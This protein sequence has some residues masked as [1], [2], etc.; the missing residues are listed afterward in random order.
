MVVARSVVVAHRNFRV[1]NEPMKELG[2]TVL[3]VARHRLKA[4]EQHVIDGAR[5]R[6]EVAQPL[7]RDRVSNPAPVLRGSGSPDE[8]P[9]AQAS[10][11]DGRRTVV[12]VRSLSELFDRSD[13]PA[14]ER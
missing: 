9:F 10:Y 1:N 6:T 3:L 14:R 4:L 13:I 7:G 8:P 2:Q 5:R 12:G 11:Y